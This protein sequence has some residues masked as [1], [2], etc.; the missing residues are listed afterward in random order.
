MRKRIILTVILLSVICIIMIF[1][2]SYIW[3]EFKYGNPYKYLIL[4]S[5][6]LVV[7]LFALYIVSKIDYKLYLKY[8]NMI[9]LISFLLLILVL[10]P[11]IGNVR[12]GS[13]SWFSIGSIGFQ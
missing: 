7:S 3:S 8:S 1:S 13:R 11:G 12:N 6:F 9:L 5:I 4:Q 2:S 10:I